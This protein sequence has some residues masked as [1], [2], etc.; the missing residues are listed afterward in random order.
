MAFEIINPE[1]D[2]RFLFLCDHA[3]NAL[4]EGY[5]TLGLGAEQ[6]QRHIAWDVGAGD[7]VRSLSQAFHAPAVLGRY[8]RLLIDLNREPLDPTLIMQIS[9]GAV[10][11]G[12]ARI[13]KE[14]R[15]H[16]LHSYFEPYHQAVTAEIDRAL[17]AGKVPLL[18]S[19]HSFT[20]SWKGVDRPWHIGLLWDRDGRAVEPLEEI[21]GRN[22]DLVVG[23]NEP[24]S[25]ELRGDCLYTHGSLRGL[26]HVLIEI[27]QDLLRAEASKKAWALL[28]EDA[29]RELLLHEHIW[30][31]EH[32]GSHAH[33]DGSD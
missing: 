16:R 14:E 25:G 9:D 7:V 13:D 19:V 10:I 6:L 11:P 5:G 20:E 23:D 8:S 1:G 29:L 22:D 12:N 15:E 17:E 28:L 3:S 27:R 30:K 4:P 32:F 21:L 18:V 24:Y 26:P 31:I 33:E 2:P